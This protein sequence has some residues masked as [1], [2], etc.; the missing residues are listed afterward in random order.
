[1]KTYRIVSRPTYGSGMN[2]DRDGFRVG[3]RVH[4]FEDDLTPDVDGDVKLYPVGGNPDEWVYIGARHIA[5]VTED[6]DATGRAALIQQAKDLLRPD[7]TAHELIAMA[8]YL[9]GGAA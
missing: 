3:D 2:F 7:A 1:M 4:A 5:E 8:D 9:A 6:S